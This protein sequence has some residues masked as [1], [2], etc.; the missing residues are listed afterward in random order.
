M[1]KAGLTLNDLHDTTCMT[2]NRFS[3]FHCFYTVIQIVHTEYKSCSYRLFIEA[4]VQRC[5]AIKVFLK[6]SQNSQ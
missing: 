6:M 1:L 5:S 2:H 4:V 3:D